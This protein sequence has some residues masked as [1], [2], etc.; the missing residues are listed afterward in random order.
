MGRR[1]RTIRPRRADKPS[2]F[3]IARSEPPARRSG[4]W[5]APSRSP[6]RSQHLD[7]QTLEPAFPIGTFAQHGLGIQR[8]PACCLPH[9]FTDSSL[10][11]SSP[12]IHHRPKPSPTRWAV[13]A[14]PSDP[15]RVPPADFKIPCATNLMPTTMVEKRQAPRRARAG[16]LSHRLWDGCAAPKSP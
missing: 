12:W 15:F 9:R 6:S 7:R 13:T 3:V 11:F 2:S 14:D 4:S 1:C 16:T 8:R 10:D 5:T